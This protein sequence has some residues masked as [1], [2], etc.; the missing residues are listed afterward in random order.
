MSNRYY[1]SPDFYIQPPNPDWE[2]LLMILVAF[3]IL[4]FFLT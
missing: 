3:I 1:S 4:Y 2:E